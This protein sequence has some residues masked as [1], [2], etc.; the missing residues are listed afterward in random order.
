MIGAGAP[1]AR[2]RVPCEAMRRLVFLVAVLAL[3]ATACGDDDDS[4][5]ASPTTSS[6]AATTTTTTTPTTT[7]SLVAATT[8]KAVT[9]QTADGLTL[10]GRLF[11]DGN[12]AVVLAHMRPADQTSWFDFARVLADE[13]YRALAFNFRG[14]GNSDDG[15]LSDIDRDLAAAVDFVRSEGATDVAVMGASMG[16]TA[17]VAAATD[18]AAAGVV[19]LSAPDTFQGIDA[20]AAAPGLTVPALYIAAENDEPYVT[21]AGVLAAATP[22]G[23]ARVYAGSRHGT[24]L[25]A[26]HPA[27]LTAQLLTFLEGAF[28]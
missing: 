24:D 9:F 18:A 17:A 12:R 7:T 13:G 25:F 10:E 11:G 5:A 6:A 3:A 2:S 23:D 20:T 16:G 21:A 8:E 27:D 19:S 28:G 26:D 22:A 15:D 14:Y 1:R 4:G